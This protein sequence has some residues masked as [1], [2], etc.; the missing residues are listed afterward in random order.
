MLHPAL[1]QWQ[2]PVHDL[3][4]QDEPS[5]FHESQYAESAILRRLRKFSLLRSGK[6]VKEKAINGR[7]DKP[8]KKLCGSMSMSSLIE[9]FAFGAA[10]SQSRT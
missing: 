9:P 8:H 3:R 5:F 10:A 4:R 7:H 2:L 1:L 6:C